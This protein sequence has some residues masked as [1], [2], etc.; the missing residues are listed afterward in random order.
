MFWLHGNLVGNSNTC[1]NV[2]FFKLNNK[3]EF[4]LSDFG[5]SKKIKNKILSSYSYMSPEMI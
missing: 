4:K 5:S 3:Y 1:Y 2:T